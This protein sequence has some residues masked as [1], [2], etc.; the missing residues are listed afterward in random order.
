MLNIFT[1]LAQ[2]SD[3]WHELRS[4]SIGASEAPVI[5]EVSPWKTP[6]QLYEDKLSRNITIPNAAMKR[7]LNL[8]SVARKRLEAI[9]NIEFNPV[10]CFHH[11]LPF[12]IASLDGLSSDNKYIVEIKC[13]GAADHKMA[14]DGKIPYHYYPQLQHQMMVTGHQTNYYYSFNG[15][16]GHLVPCQRNEE[17]IKEL[18][19]KEKDFYSCLTNKIPPTPTQKDCIKRKDENWLNISSQWKDAKMRLDAIE[20]EESMLREQ[21]I[22]LSNDQSSEGNGVKALRTTRKGNV[23]YSLVPEFFGVDLEIYRKPNSTVWKVM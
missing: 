6:L 2:Q 14:R 9:F 10:V 13:P 23:D 16:E 1:N 11:E 3:E 20:K 17:Y 5:M 7:G 15:E 8:E 21:L 12:L 18:I 4:K 19:T 22:E